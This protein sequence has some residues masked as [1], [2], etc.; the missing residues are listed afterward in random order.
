MIGIEY[1]VLHASELILAEKVEEAEDV[2]NA[3]EE[4]EDLDDGGEVEHFVGALFGRLVDEESLL[5]VVG[6]RF[7]C[8]GY[9]QHEDSR[10]QRNKGDC[11][12]F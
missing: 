3:S 10:L 5:V 1:I 9:D 11:H 6:H 12:T 7:C 8:V 2:E 4:V